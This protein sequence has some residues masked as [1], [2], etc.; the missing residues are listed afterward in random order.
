M[1]G[2]LKGQGKLVNEIKGMKHA[3]KKLMDEVLAS[4]GVASERKSQKSKELITDLTGRI[5]K[6][7]ERLMEL[8]YLI[9]EANHQLL[10]AGVE[11]CYERMKNRKS[12]LDELENEV[13]MMREILKSKVAYQVQLHEEWESL[14]SLMHDIMGPKVIELFDKDEYNGE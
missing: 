13:N 9:K 14:Y 11:I 10:V 5:D 6:N 8:P 1:E 4:M 2:V 12:E 3:K 7:T